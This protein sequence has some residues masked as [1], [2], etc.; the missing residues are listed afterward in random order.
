MRF[1]PEASGP[2]LRL[3]HDAGA[4]LLLV[5]TL[6]PLYLLLNHYWQSLLLLLAFYGLLGLLCLR[7]GSLFRR[8]IRRLPA[9]LPPWSPAAGG[10]AMTVHGLEAQPHSVEAMHSVC[11]DP[12]YVQEVF[13]PRLRALIAYRLSG[14]DATPFEALTPEQQARLD[15]FVLHFLQ[16][17]EQQTLWA[18]YSQRRRRLAEA[19][20]LLRRIEA[21]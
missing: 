14:S 4:L 17:Q 3:L 21:L 10:P 1:M 8:T 18:R 15:A 12:C 2:G 9:E 5:L 7:L 13:K 19:L 20:E 11:V 16:R 6:V